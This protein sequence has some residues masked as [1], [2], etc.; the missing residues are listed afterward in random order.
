[1]LLVPS[2]QNHFYFFL[3]LKQIC[4]TRFHNQGRKVF[5]RFLFFFKGV[6]KNLN[7]SEKPYSDCGSTPQ[8]KRFR[9]EHKISKTLLFVKKKAKGSKK[10]YENVFV[11]YPIFL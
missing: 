8:T 7:L 11:F 5:F 1:M 3:P 6:K 10:M 9:V 4:H 2:S